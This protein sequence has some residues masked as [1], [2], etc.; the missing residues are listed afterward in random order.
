MIPCKELQDRQ[1]AA[2]EIAVADSFSRY[3]ALVID[4]VLDG[5]AAG[6]KARMHDLRQYRRTEHASSMQRFVLLVEEV[7]AKEIG[8]WGVLRSLDAT[9]RFLEA[10]RILELFREAIVNLP[11]TMRPK[12]RDRIW[13]WVAEKIDLESS[14]WL[15]GEELTSLLD[16][17]EFEAAGRKRGEDNATEEENRSGS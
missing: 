8:L 10:K 12:A 9:H 14:D 7:L 4:S 13:A 6:V 11:E 15:Y 16:A 17:F 1:R 3:V 5:D 2:G